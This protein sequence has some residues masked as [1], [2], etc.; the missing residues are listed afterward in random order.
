MTNVFFQEQI[1]CY[2]VK[3]DLFSELLK[4]NTLTYADLYSIYID[5]KGDKIK[6]IT[7]DE[8]T[9][10]VISFYN[11][12]KY[13]RNLIKNGV[14]GF[15]R[16]LENY[17]KKIK[18]GPVQE[19]MKEYCINLC[20]ENNNVPIEEKEGM[21]Y[22]V[23]LL[24]LKSTAQ[25]YERTK[26]IINFL[27]EQAEIDKVTVNQLIGVITKQLNYHTEKR[28][29]AT[30]ISEKLIN[31]DQQT[32]AMSLPS[33][34]F[35]QQSLQ[36]GR[37]G[38]QLLKSVLKQSFEENGATSPKFPAW[39]TV[40]VYQKSIMPSIKRDTELP[41][42]RLKYIDALK[43][44]IVRI[45]CLPQVESSNAELTVQIKDGVDGSGGHSIYHQ[46][47]NEQTHNMIMFMFAVLQIRE[48]DTGLLTCV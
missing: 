13:D 35:L 28:N 16:V 26:P 5:S 40:R 14:K 19:E 10:L 33:T 31:E 11:L 12:E 39:K 36:L 22:R 17:R 34:C 25:R 41:G 42:V 20:D 21:K 2:Y 30:F 44:T 15:F 38:Y 48:T 29:S 37:T 45:L 7:T 24:D 1:F 9:D 6:K 43:V 23:S 27:E 4:M 8:L 32:V 46:L 3:Y 47:G 18:K